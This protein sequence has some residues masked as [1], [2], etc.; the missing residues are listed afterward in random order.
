MPKTAERPEERLGTT[1]GARIPDVV[2]YARSRKA[3]RSCR[4][5]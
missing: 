1:K 2:N 5:A 4:S 3:K